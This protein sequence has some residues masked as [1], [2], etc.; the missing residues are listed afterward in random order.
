MICLA[1]DLSGKGSARK[2]QE[3][4]NCKKMKRQTC[5]ISKRK[6]IKQ[7]H[8]LILLVV[9]TEPVP[10][11]NVTALKSRYPGPQRNCLK[12]PVPVP[13]VTALKSR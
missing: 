5:Q 9:S 1:Y 4:Q 8:V 11:P 10:V 7:V 12:E 6:C 13:N 3:I 2:K